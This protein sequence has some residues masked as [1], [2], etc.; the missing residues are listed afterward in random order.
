MFTGLLQQPRMQFLGGSVL[1]ILTLCMAF[2]LQ[3]PL[4]LA[5]PF[6]FVAGLYFLRDFRIPFF[7]LMA[8]LPVSFNLQEMIG[9]GLDFPD[10]PLMLLLTGGFFIVVLLNYHDAKLKAW[11]QHPLILLVLAGFCWM[12]VTV[13]FSMNPG[14]SVKYFLKRIWYIFPFLAFPY[15]IFRNTSNMRKS[16]LFLFLPLLAVVLLVL[17]RYSAL[18]FRFEMVHDPIQ[19]FFVN[20]V[21]YGSMISCMV[22]LIAG[23]FVYRKRFSFSWLFM[24]GAL[25]IFLVAV[26]FSYSRAAWMAV[27]F[28]LAAMV[29]IHFRVM[30]YAMILFFTVVLSAVIWLAN[31]NTYLTFRPKF[32]KTIMHES[33]ADHIMATI[34]GT[35]I[36][37][38]E[39][40]YRW[41]AAV[42]MS[43][44]RPLTGV[45]PNNFYDYYKS[46]TIAAYRTWVSRNLE[47]STTHNYFLFMLVEQ[48]YPA[49][50]LYAML[51]LAIFYY[52]QR[53]YHRQSDR[54]NRI[55]V[56]SVL[57][58]IAAL[59]IN[60]F[61]SEL[62]ETDKIGSLFLLGISL[63]V[64]IDLSTR[65]SQD[66]P[67]L[68]SQGYN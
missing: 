5:L 39:R 18:G 67:V 2:W 48:G 14:L 63:L 29:M 16:F 20:H 50:I 59:F 22:P 65:K 61:F 10:E 62:L 40:Y 25:V 7:L 51:I 52:G 44:D 47:R 41:I 21:M 54:M 15:F 45:G 6:V 11:I 60:N 49:M 57:C 56:M 33:I 28:A 55:T 53:I 32:E 35:D 64:T 12:I 8:A 27:I 38:A 34:Q 46:Y 43:A 17:Y 58:M 4:L 68:T 9:V 24:L 26:Y 36:S 31:D 30:H 3:Q 66:H 37:S 19:P 1:L 42:R 23:A 13:V